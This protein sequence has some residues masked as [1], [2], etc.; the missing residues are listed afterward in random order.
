[1][2]IRVALLA[3]LL[4]VVVGHS[5]AS[6]QGK[7]PPPLV[8]P[9]PP[10]PQPAQPDIKK[11][12]EAYS[13]AGDP[14]IQFASG[15]IPNFGRV[16]VPQVTNELIEKVQS[17]ISLI[18][19]KAR[20][21]DLVASGAAGHLFRDVREAKLFEMAGE[22]NARDLLLQKFNSDI[23]IVIKYY[24]ADSWPSVK[25]RGAL[26]GVQ[27]EMIERS[28]GRQIGGYNFDW[29]F[30]AD[31]DRIREY[32]S[33][34]SR[35][36]ID[37]FAD[38][39]SRPGAAGATRK[40]TM[41]V[42]NLTGLERVKGVETAMKKIQGVQKVK[43]SEFTS[44]GTASVAMFNVDY[45]GSSLDLAVDLLTRARE[46]L[47]MKLDGIDTS[48][49]SIVLVAGKEAEIEVVRPATRAEILAD[50]DHPLYKPTVEALVAEYHRR[51]SPRIGIIIN[52]SLRE[53]ETSD[54]KLA[55]Q[56]NKANQG[57]AVGQNQPSNAGSGSLV[58]INVGGK[59]GKDS[60][61]L[62]NTL[63]GQ[64]KTAPNNPASKQIVNADLLDTRRMEDELSKL[65]IKMGLRIHDADTVRGRLLAR[66]TNAR[67]VFS[68]NEL[69]YMLSQDA[70][71]AGL[72]VVILG[73]GRVDKRSDR[74]GGA[75]ADGA[76][77]YTLRAV[78]L[79]DGRTLGAEGFASD[80]FVGSKR[81]TEL[82]V[83][84]F[85]QHLVANLMEQMWTTWEPPQEMSVTVA[86][87]KTQRDVI[88]IMSVFEK[89]IPGVKSVTFLKHQAGAE[90]G[91]GEFRLSYT[92]SYEE[93]VKEVIA[94]SKEL[95]FDLDGSETRRDTLL[96]KIRS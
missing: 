59:D 12:E 8:K 14:T 4:L 84:F 37:Q 82:T 10:P 62:D 5:P 27:I 74:P 83:R 13:A 30:S 3:A 67:V 48:N 69:Q 6:G 55:D 88:T 80:N 43:F 29:T 36:I 52:R 93:F 28:R 63:P 11:F 51:G 45:S 16:D 47:K 15:L 73:S 46:D 76:I 49:N 79:S 41:K 54:P 26:M 53:D 77:S 61:R 38:W 90:G 39:Y 91:I 89:E 19:R 20:D 35:R 32:A 42:V 24:D 96:I 68:E 60:S 81:V 64:D 85:A 18:F 87:A 56:I 92:T 58:I 25:K 23:I 40:F 2:K 7:A 21:I 78:R 86:N 17:E 33:A 66:A 95:P 9:P 34:M 94:R 65:M 31:Q 72:D 57:A 75:N 22:K 70:K 71:E 1:M 50:P 44:D